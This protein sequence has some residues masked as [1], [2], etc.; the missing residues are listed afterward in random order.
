[1]LPESRLCLE[2]TEDAVRD[3]DNDLILGETAAGCR[4]LIVVVCCR[5]WH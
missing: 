2:P 4:I 3:R 5:D 1:M